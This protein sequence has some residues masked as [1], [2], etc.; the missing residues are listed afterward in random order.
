MKVKELIE[1]L[2][3]LDPEQCVTCY[4]EDE[5]LKT[6]DGPVQIF[7]IQDVSEAETESSRLNEGS[8]KPW[9]KFGKS[10]NSSKF[11]LLEITSD[12]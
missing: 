8:G 2:Q 7:K 9:L 1:E 12:I 10:D 11:V 4:S 3:K 6:N 5:G